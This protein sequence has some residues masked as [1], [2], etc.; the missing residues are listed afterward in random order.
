MIDM[1]LFEYKI[2]D[3]PTKFS[4]S[5]GKMN[6]QELADKLN[7]L[8]RQGWEVVNTID[9]NMYQGASRGLIIILKKSL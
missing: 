1:N 7:D 6:V 2:L 9:T 3:V 8:G 4:W 5:G